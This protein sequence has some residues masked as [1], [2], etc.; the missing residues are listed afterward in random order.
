M[1]TG[2]WQ[3]RNAWLYAERPSKTAVY[4]YDDT[5]NTVSV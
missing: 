3:A 1:K 5:T 4:Q 2:T